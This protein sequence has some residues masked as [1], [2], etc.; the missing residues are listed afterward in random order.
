[1]HWEKVWGSRIFIFFQS[2]SDN[3]FFKYPLRNFRRI[4]S[5]QNE[6]KMRG[7][8]YQRNF[9]FFVFCKNLKLRYEE[10]KWS[11]FWWIWMEDLANQFFRILVMANCWDAFSRN[12]HRFLNSIFFIKNCSF[13]EVIWCLATS[14]L[15]RKFKRFNLMKKKSRTLL[16]E[17]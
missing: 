5:T 4:M 10:Q 1:M 16:I 3:L 9:R 13:Q 12:Y 11:K 15:N 17:K 2:L 6:A 14:T 8:G 7:Y